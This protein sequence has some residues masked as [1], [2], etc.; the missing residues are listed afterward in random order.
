MIL[1]KVVAE[2]ESSYPQSYAIATEI[3]D[4]IKE[5]IYPE[6]SEDERLYFVIHIQRLITEPPIG[7]N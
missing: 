3:F 6:M 1:P 4:E 5:K 2:L 7:A